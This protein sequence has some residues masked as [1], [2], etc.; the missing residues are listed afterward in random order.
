MGACP[1]LPHCSFCLYCLT[2]SSRYRAAQDTEQHGDLQWCWLGG[3]EREGS[4]PSPR[5]ERC[6]AT[7]SC[8]H[9]PGVTSWPTLQLPSFLTACHLGHPSALMHRQSG[10][11]SGAAEAGSMLSISWVLSQEIPVIWYLPGSYLKIPK[12]NNP[13]GS[14]RP[15]QF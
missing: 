1:C 10:L 9:G 4:V 3:S 2:V 5:M 7:R 13:P 14:S 12:E 15:K 8:T 11:P 6:S